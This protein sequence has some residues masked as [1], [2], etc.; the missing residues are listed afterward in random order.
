M[1]YTV[2]TLCSTSFASI[3]NT[4]IQ[5]GF[6]DHVHTAQRFSP[7]LHH[8]M[9]V[10]PVCLLHSG[11][12]GSCWRWV[13]I[14]KRAW[15]FM[16][17][18]GRTGGHTGPED[19]ECAAARSY[20]PVIISAL[21]L[22]IWITPAS[23]QRRMDSY[24]C[25]DIQR[26]LPQIIKPGRKEKTGVEEERKW[27]SHQTQSRRWEEGNDKQQLAGQEKKWKMERNRREDLVNKTETNLNK[28]LINTLSMQCM[29]Y[30]LKG[31]V[32]SI[33]L[34]SE[35]DTP[36]PS[37]APPHKKYHRD[38][39]KKWSKCAAKCFVTSLVIT[40]ILDDG[41]VK[42]LMLIIIQKNIGKV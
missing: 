19:D 23:L 27:Q 1:H 12:D 34:A 33:H 28:C 36:L 20:Y 2:Y 15:R 30:T 18:S 9:L 24:S 5:Q 31:A 39:S 13:C 35:L 42:I 16:S 8:H 41:W 40:C 11:L 38:Y 3:V 10:I 14:M 26:R 21:N 22:L 29:I 32:R 37:K 25:E 6:P 4:L 7:R 17:V